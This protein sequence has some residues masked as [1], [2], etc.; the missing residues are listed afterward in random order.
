MTQ[1]K[2][3]ALTGG[4]GSGKS[5]AAALLRAWGYP[6]LS[7]DEIYAELCQEESFLRELK[8]LFPDCVKEDGLDRP[9]LSRTVFSDE[10]ALGRLNGFTHP[11]IMERLLA[12]MQSFPLSFAEVPLLFEEG[13]QNMFDGVLVVLRGKR[14]RIEGVKARSGLSEEEILARMERQ[15][16]YAALPKGCVAIRNDG[17]LLELEDE[18]RRALKALGV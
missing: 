8:L 6:V 14:A 1:S 15:F 10:A 11:R 3:I 13:Y 18:L 4:I 12:R 9:T 5:T 16:D 7:C 17:T 2:K